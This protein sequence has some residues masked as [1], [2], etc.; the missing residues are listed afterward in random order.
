MLIHYNFPFS[1]L[2]LLLYILHLHKLQTQQYIA[3]IALY[4]FMS[5]KG[6]KKERTNM[7]LQ[8]LLYLAFYLPFLVLVICPV[9]LIYH[10]TSFP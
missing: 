7:Y 2:L 4:Y 6:A 1:Q 10:L 9:D 8:C 5:F 3:I